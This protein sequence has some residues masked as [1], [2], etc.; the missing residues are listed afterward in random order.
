MT[1][2]D[3][4]K[5]NA[6]SCAEFHKTMARAHVDRAAECETSSGKD[7][8]NAC[9]RNHADEAERQIGMFKSL[10]AVRGDDIGDVRPSTISNRGNLDAMQATAAIDD[11]SKIRPDGIHAVLPDAPG[12]LR[13]I[14]RD[15]GG[16]PPIEIDEIDESLR[17]L[18]KN[19]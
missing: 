10:G 18:V 17:E 1:L 8:H 7:F 11:L 3:C 19:S 16:N 12:K 14:A 6:L 2:N 13:L 5:S 9:A 4:L 15:G